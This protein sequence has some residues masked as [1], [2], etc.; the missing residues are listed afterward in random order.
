MMLDLSDREVKYLVDVL[1]EAHKGLLHELNHTD[2]GDYKQLLHDQVKL[3]DGLMCRL[4]AA[5]TSV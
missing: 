2:V 4:R 5:E 3:N 1:L